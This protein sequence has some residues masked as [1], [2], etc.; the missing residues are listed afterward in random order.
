NLPLI[1]DLDTKLTACLGRN[2]RFFLILQSF[3][4]LKKYP[5]GLNDT[6]LSNCGYMFYIKSPSET[7]N[8]IIS[9]RL[10][11]RNVWKMSRQGRFFSLFKSENE[12]IEKEE[13]M[14]VTE[15]EQLQFGE[16][17]ILRIMTNEDKDENEI[18][19]YPILNRGKHRFHRHYSYLQGY[20]EMSWEEI[21]EVN[22]G[23]HTKVQL[24][25]LVTT[26]DPNVIF[27]DEI[28][29]EKEGNAM[30]ETSVDGITAPSDVRAIEKIQKEREKALYSIYKMTNRQQKCANYYDQASL[31]LLKTQIKKTIIQEKVYRETILSMLTND[32][33]ENFIQTLLPMKS[34]QHFKKIVQVLHQLEQAA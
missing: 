30:P 3:S 26:L 18:T 12:S 24:G 1:N 33:L 23:A 32:T 29:R 14:N 27:L 34:A 6:I 8:D 2:I 22:D 28:R 20:K 5:E 31:E 25:D 19:A 16:N 15:L 9:K 13:L 10:N 11:K 7:T 17:V 21:P 4:Q